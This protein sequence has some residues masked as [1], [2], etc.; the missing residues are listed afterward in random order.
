M[1]KINHPTSLNQYNAIGIMSG[2]SLDGVD[3]CLVSFREG[4]SWSFEIQ[5]S[6][7]IPI[8]DEIKHEL[9]KSDALTGYELSRLDIRYGEWIGQQLKAFSP[10]NQRIDAVGFHGHTVFHEPENKLSLQIGN[11]SVI[12]SVSGL[13]VVD[14]FRT[15]DILLGGQGAPLV[16][17]G[18]TLLFPG[19]KAWINLGGIANITVEN[20]ENVLAWDIAPCNQVFN[21]F[22]Q[23]LNVPYDNDGALAKEGSLDEKW[24]DG[25][26]DLPYF[27][28]KPPKSMS[29]QWITEHILKYQPKDPKNALHSYAE[30][31]AAEIAQSVGLY[32]RGKERVL[33]T[34]GGAHNSYLLGRIKIFLKDKNIEIIKPSVAIIDF[35]EALIFGFLGLLRKLG[36]PNTLGM[37]TGA[38]KDTVSGTLHLP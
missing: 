36:I 37:A 15:K 26:K 32:L 8:P 38:S 12:S 27:K 4:S 10:Q 19:Y 24:I 33:V 34:G 3:F 11:G 28:T 31:L 20:S 23:K 2:S 9:K 7:T 6:T 30:F 13:P 21:F 5:Q 22:A 18:E 35:K 1:G 25:L 16:P 14:D 17:K 29:N